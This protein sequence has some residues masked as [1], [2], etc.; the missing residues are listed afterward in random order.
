MSD[1]SGFS[2]ESASACILAEKC[3]QGITANVENCRKY[4]EASIALITAVAPIIGYENA[5]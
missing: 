4:A 5:V 2:I 3:V 1:T